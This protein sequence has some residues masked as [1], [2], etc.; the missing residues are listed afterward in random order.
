MCV[1]KSSIWHT[2]L[3]CVP[4][5]HGCGWPFYL[6]L[7]FLNLLNG[8]HHWLLQSFFFLPIS[9]T[10]CFSWFSILEH[11]FLSYFTSC[12][13]IN[14]H[15]IHICNDYLCLSNRLNLWSYHRFPMK[16]FIYLNKLWTIHHFMSIQTTN[17]TCI[18]RCL[19]CFLIWLCH[20]YGYHRGLF[21]FL[22]ACLHIVIYHPTICA[23]FVSFP[24][25][26]LCFC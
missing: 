11:L 12:G 23:M 17:V 10:L 15:H 4:S 20:L 6:G 9:N 16:H 13:N 25:I 26:I 22:F 7:C 21:F 2:W 19:L 5:L 8:F 18:W 14:I 1:D 24:C 3:G